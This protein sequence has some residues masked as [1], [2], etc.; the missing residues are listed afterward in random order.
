MTFYIIV[1]SIL[2]V[3]IIGFFTT[4]YVLIK[5]QPD[6]QEEKQDTDPQNWEPEPEEPEP[7]A[8]I[9]EF[10]DESL[11]YLYSY[12]QKQQKV[13]VRY[14]SPF[15]GTRAT[16]A[17]EP[18]GN[19]EYADVKGVVINYQFVLL[20]VFFHKMLPGDIREVAK[21]FDG[22]LPNIDQ[23]VYIYEHQN[24]ISR[25][26]EKIG[27]ARLEK[28]NY[29]FT[30][31]DESKDDEFNHC[32][33]FCNGHTHSADPDEEVSAFLITEFCPP[34]PA[35]NKDAKCEEIRKN[36]IYGIE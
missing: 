19:K 13:V 12:G 23:L 26:L 3:M 28:T 20:R 7:E 1:Y 24:E 9:V 32:I 14:E 25:R 6:K 22:H 29:L 18:L 8:E 30:W 33:N 34:P 21:H 11:P 27:E 16:A 31:D 15:L 17:F 4:A 36:V 35:A 5:R 10:T 2:A